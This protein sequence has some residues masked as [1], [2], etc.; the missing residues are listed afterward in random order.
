M[1]S[2]IA[3]TANATRSNA[4]LATPCNATRSAAYVDTALDAVI[5]NFY[6]WCKTPSSAFSKTFSATTPNLFA[7]FR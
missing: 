5:L 3:R 7:R 2:S 4:Q 1:K 6:E